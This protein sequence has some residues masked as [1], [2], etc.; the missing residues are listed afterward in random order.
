MRPDFPRRLKQRMLIRQSLIFEN[1]LYKVAS[2]MDEYSDLT[3]LEARLLRAAEA[4]L[5][6][7]RAQQRDAQAARGRP[8]SR[9]PVEPFAG[10]FT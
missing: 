4:I 8:S 6:A 9:L 1:F 2:S 5:L 7:R 3:T 10:G